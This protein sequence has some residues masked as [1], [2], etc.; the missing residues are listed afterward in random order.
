MSVASTLS[1]PSVHPRHA[2][3]DSPAPTPA[4]SQRQIQSHNQSQS[5]SRIPIQTA[6]APVFTE[7]ELHEQRLQ[8]EILRLISSQKPN[9]LHIR[10]RYAD[11]ICPRAHADRVRERYGEC[12]VVLGAVVLDLGIHEEERT[13]GR[14]RPREGDSMVGKKRS[15]VERRRWLEGVELRMRQTGRYASGEVEL[16]GISEEVREMPALRRMSGR[17]ETFQELE[18]IEVRKEVSDVRSMGGKHTG[19]STRSIEPFTTAAKQSISTTKA[20]VPSERSVQTLSAPEPHGVLNSMKHVVFGTKYL[21]RAMALRGSGQ[22]KRKQKQRSRSADA[23]VPSSSTSIKPRGTT[24]GLPNEIA[25]GSFGARP[26]LEQEKVSKRRWWSTPFSSKAASPGPGPGP[27]NKNAPWA[28]EPEQPKPRLFPD[29]KVGATRHELG[30]APGPSSKMPRDDAEKSFDL[31]CEPSTEP[32]RSTAQSKSITAPRPS[33]E[34]ATN[35]IPRIRFDEPA[36]EAPQPNLWQPT[37]K[38]PRPSLEQSTTKKPAVSFAIPSPPKTK[39]AFPPTKFNTFPP[40]RLALARSAL[41][42]TPGYGVAEPL[43][44][45]LEGVLGDDD[46]RPGS[47]S[48]LKL[49]DVLVDEKAI[50]IQ[51]SERLDHVSEIAATEARER[52]R[53]ARAANV[54]QRAVRPYTE[55]SNA[56]AR[57]EVTLMKRD[58][59]PEPMKGVP[60]VRVFTTE[61]AERVQ[62]KRVNVGEVDCRSVAAQREVPP[63]KQNAEATTA[64][65]KKKMLLQNQK[66]PNEDVIIAIR[67]LDEAIRDLNARAAA[68]PEA[69]SVAKQDASTAPSTKRALNTPWEAA[70]HHDLPVRLR[71]DRSQTPDTCSRA[72]SVPCPL[73]DAVA[74]AEALEQLHEQD[75]LVGLREVTLAKRAK[76]VRRADGQRRSMEAIVDEGPARFDSATGMN[77][78]QILEGAKRGMEGGAAPEGR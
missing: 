8:L 39:P 27:W 14:E 44:P 70:W 29:S 12:K 73:S 65:S 36:N 69:S 35:K 37:N 11:A 51:C 13:W 34:E 42:R 63:R 47:K 56:A 9:T 32:C 30:C 7:Q 48:P 77:E 64:T 76:L 72:P 4:L 68:H 1:F 43:A 66:Q 50:W 61:T 54:A 58:T 57:S 2:M 28:L 10:Q 19:P 59:T 24:S 41:P 67:G 18:V 78:A 25:A 16:D 22:K 20:A 75:V 23:R 45:Q 60:G 38:A 46:S 53:R 5:Q 17:R 52:I 26:L 6:G 49:D 33:F 3:S 21:K 62:I 15:C 74:E 55:K 40:S 71:G 31:N